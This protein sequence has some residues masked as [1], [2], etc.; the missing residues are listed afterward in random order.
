LQQPHPVGV[1]EVEELIEIPVEVVREVS[2]LLPEVALR[3]P[4]EP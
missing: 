1:L 4:A 3:V 2:D